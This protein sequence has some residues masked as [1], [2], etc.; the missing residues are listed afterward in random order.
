MSNTTRIQAVLNQNYFREKPALDVYNQLLADDEW[1][2]RRIITEALIALGEK[3]D[4]GWQV[5]DV[6]DEVKVSSK[7]I[8]AFD[9]L[10]DFVDMIAEMDIAELRQVKGFNESVYQSLQAEGLKRG[11]ARMLSDETTFEDEDW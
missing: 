10:S 1:T 6:P 7:L 3:H 9:K 11:A 8:A 5:A 4:S 2:S